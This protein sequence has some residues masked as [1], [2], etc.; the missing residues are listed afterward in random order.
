MIL[1]SG[2]LGERGRVSCDICIIGA[3]AAGITLACELD[4]HSAS[5]VLL[6]SAGTGLIGSVSQDSYVGTSTES[7]PPPSYFRRLAFG[8]STT[9]WGG[10]CVP[11]EPIDFER[12]VYVANSGWPI[13]YQD[14]AR[15]YPKAMQYCDVGNFDFS[16]SGALED[17]SPTIPGLGSSTDLETNVIERYSLPT[18]FGSRYKPKLKK[19]RNVR[20]VTNAHAIRT[21]IASTA[22]RVETVEFSTKSGENGVVT[23]K[24]FVLAMGGIETTRFLLASNMN[25]IALGNHADKLG[26]YYTCHLENVIGALRSNGAS[27]P[28]LFQKTHDGIYARRKIQLTEDAQRRER[29]LNIAFRLHYPNIAEPEHKSSVLSAVY[30][31][32]KL[33][34]PEYR[35]ILQHG[36]A[37]PASVGNVLAHVRNVAAGVPELSRFS[38]DWTRRRLLARRKLPYM[39]VANADG[40]YPIEF[41]AEQTPLESSRITLSTEAD[42]FG[43]P[44]VRIDWRTSDI[45]ID[46]ISRAYRLL[47][48]CLERTAACR[49]ELEDNLLARQASE[50]GPVGGHHIGTARMSDVPSGG[51][52]DQNCRVFGVSNLYVA[53][54]AVFPTSSHAN[55]TLTIVALAIRLATH[56]STEIAKA[57]TAQPSYRS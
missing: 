7:H 43:I 9:I 25:S 24:I 42:Q 51:V 35:R 37:G 17:Q 30:L 38:L 57:K 32:K 39:L 1:S 13:S 44:R 27:I 31:A 36:H 4:G 6:E 29:I 53:S 15:H 49:V 33:I 54:S 50:S 41:H 28:F 3:G 22:E 8:G 46:S 52:V 40:S 23:A 18:D 12:R 56:L 10:R 48:S 5:V 16:V 34:V 21:R 19:S 2:S 47:R 45:D 14:V 11:Y 26:R 55:P 20:V